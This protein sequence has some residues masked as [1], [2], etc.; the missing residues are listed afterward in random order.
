MLRRT[1]PT[2]MGNDMRRKN[3]FIGLLAFSLCGQ[4]APVQAAEPAYPI[5]DVPGIEIVRGD[6]VHIEGPKGKAIAF[7]LKDGRMCVYGDGARFAYWSEDGGRSWKKGPDGPLDKMAFDFGDGEI[8]SVKRDLLRRDDGK[9]TAKYYRSTDNWNTVHA[10]TGI[11]DIPLAA[12]TLDENMNP[13]EGML[14]HHGIVQ[15]ADGTM[16]ATVY[17]NYEGDHILCDAHPPRFRNLKTR[18]VVIS[19]P[20]RGKTWGNPVMVAYDTMLGVETDT[21]LTIVPAVTQEGFNEPD[22]TVAPN[23][24]V[25]C[26]MRSGGAVGAG[27][28][29][30]FPTP[31]YVSRSSDNGKTWCPPEQM[32]DRGVCPNLVTL[33]NGIIVCSYSRPGAWLIFSDD[34]GKTWN[35]PT[36]FGP[37]NNYVYVVDVGPDE[38]LTFREGLNSGVDAT[39]FT[40]RKKS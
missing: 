29:T 15:L 28:I 4:V 10:A 16:L 23:G 31:L 26:V 3:L 17:G 13:L 35:A 24:D 18:T 39:Y 37:N 14:M 32:A 6:D 36:Q 38:I 12:A 2:M 33:E 34:N 5:P 7:K 22:L 27:L 8:I 30:T 9:F 40:I 19:S 11:A 1:D 20:D 25:I 21:K